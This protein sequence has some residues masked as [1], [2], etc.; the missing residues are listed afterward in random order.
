M[1]KKKK[2]E[3]GDVKRKENIIK[4]FSIRKFPNAT[5]YFFWLNDSSYSVE[6]DAL[7]CQGEELVY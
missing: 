6:V 4:R 2:V 3:A 5:K 7:G 1:K